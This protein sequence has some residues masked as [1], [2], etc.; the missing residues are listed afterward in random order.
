MEG[1]LFHGR[2]G[3]RGEVRAPV[4]S[5]K[6]ILRL[7]GSSAIALGVMLGS[8]GCARAP[9][10]KAVEKAPVVAKVKKTKKKAGA[11][12]VLPEHFEPV[13][14]DPMLTRV[15]KTLESSIQAADAYWNQ[16]GVFPPG[17]SALDGCYPK[18]QEER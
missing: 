1:G 15:A 5:K 12:E 14:F 4:I 16:H 13:D 9:L 8:G 3:V 6:A 2:S 7:L 10:P 11:E 17:T 18:S